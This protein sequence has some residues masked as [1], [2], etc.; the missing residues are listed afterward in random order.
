MLAPA[1]ILEQQK[2]KSSLILDVVDL[3]N[4]LIHLDKE[5]HGVHVAIALESRCLINNFESFFSK[6]NFTNYYLIAG[7]SAGA[8]FSP[9]RGLIKFSNGNSPFMTGRR[10]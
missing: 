1:A 8:I 9:P 3:I 5:I 6:K 10:L 7:F 2:L 4:L